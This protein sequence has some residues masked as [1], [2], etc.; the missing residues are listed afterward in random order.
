ML[1]KSKVE[2]VLDWNTNN[3]FDT[4]IPQSAINPANFEIEWNHY[5]KKIPKLNSDKKY[6]VLILWTL[7]LE[8]QS[9]EA[10]NTVTQ[11]LNKFNKQDSINLYL[12]NIDKAFITAK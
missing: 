4:F 11:N 9:N 3:R 2:W 12:I 10:I 1:C 7:M 8:K 5:S 6:K